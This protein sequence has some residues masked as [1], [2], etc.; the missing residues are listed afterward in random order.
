MTIVFYLSG[1]IALLASIRVITSSNAIHALLYLVVSFLAVSIIFFVL[2][3]PFAA[4]LEVIIYAGAI[5]VLFVFVIMMVSPGPRAIAQ[6]KSWFL[7]RT[8]LIPAALVLMLAGELVYLLSIAGH[9]EV[10][11]RPVINAEE[12]GVV[13]LGPYLIGVEIAS[14]LLLVGLVG[15]YHLRCAVNWQA[16]ANKSYKRRTSESYSGKQTKQEGA[17]AEA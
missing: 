11:V 5:L 17:S 10:G 16:S 1:I 8:W 15:A 13:M 9:A 7:P 4:A 12:V 3:A 6:E 2:G 14:F